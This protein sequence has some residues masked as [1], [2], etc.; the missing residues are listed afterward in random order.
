MAK[1]DEFNIASPISPS[2]QVEESEIVEI[3]EEELSDSKVISDPR[4][5]D[6]PQQTTNNTWSNVLE[7]GNNDTDSQQDQEEEDEEDEKYPI[8]FLDVNLGKGKVDRLIIIDGDDPMSVAEDF[9]D[10]HGKSNF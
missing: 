5:S 2:S 8:L 4:T 10:Q 1:Q 7:D 3:V 9:C 6:V